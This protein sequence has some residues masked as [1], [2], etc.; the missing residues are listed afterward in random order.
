MQGFFLKIDIS[1]IIIH[2][3]YQPGAF[4]NLFEADGLAGE[5]GAEINLFPVQADASTEGDLDGVV[6]KRIGE[7]RQALIRACGRA[8][9][10][11][12]TLHTEPLMRTILVELLDEIVKLPLL[13]KTVETRRAC[14]FFFEREMHPF[15]ASILLRMTRPDPFN[16][17]TE[18]KP[19]DRKAA[20]I[21]QRITGGE[22]YAIVRTNRVGQ[23]T[24]LEQTLKGRN[25]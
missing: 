11:S 13:L 17:D 12:R 2:K 6:V 8:V 4:L 21:E 14:R 9:D 7:I 22:R 1:Q 23:T 3:T 18:T 5:D 24:F 19:P 15:V 20:E 16:A 10:F 25:C